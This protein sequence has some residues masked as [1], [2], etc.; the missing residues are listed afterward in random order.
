MRPASQCDAKISRLESKNVNL[1]SLV[2][3]RDDVLDKL[4]DQLSALENDS[5]RAVQGKKSQLSDLNKEYGQL[6]QKII[7]LSS[8]VEEKR[9]YKAAVGNSRA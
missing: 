5:N 4:K 7:V 3:E 2:K 8:V 9:L 6:E 1:A